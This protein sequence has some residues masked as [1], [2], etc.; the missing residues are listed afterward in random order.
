MK[1]DIDFINRQLYKLFIF[2][3][4]VLIFRLKLKEIIAKVSIIIPTYNR[5]NLIG[6]SIKSVLNQ[7]YKYLE[8]IVVDDGSTD[9]T[10]EEINKIEDERVRYIKLKQNSGGSNA[11][12]IGMINAT[13]KYISFQ[14]SDDIYYPDKIETQL[15][16]IINKHSNLDFCKIKVNFN[17]SH[18]QYYPNIRQEKSIQNGNLFNELISRG[19]FISTQ[20]IL[21]KKEF[22]IKYLFD[23]KMPRLQDYDLILRMIPNV[24]ISYTSN[25]LVELNLQNDSVTLSQKKLKKA[26]N[27]LLKKKFNFN[28]NQTELFTSYLNL[29]LSTLPK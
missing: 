28:S 24:R 18:S 1:F 27:I 2:T 14:D 20:A 6:N 5:G 4:L 23:P 13:G 15:K 19:N 25:V 21:A 8:V 22:I 7:T 12:N 3:L 9:N 16:N 11:R 17:S 29:I 10:I 26:V